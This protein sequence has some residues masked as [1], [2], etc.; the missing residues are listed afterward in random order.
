[1]TFNHFFILRM[2]N[3][4]KSQNPLFEFKHNYQNILFIHNV[5]LRKLLSF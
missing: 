2:L 3:N 1:M 5:D 4:Y